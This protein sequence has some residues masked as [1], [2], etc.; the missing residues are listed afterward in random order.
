VRSTLSEKE[1]SQGETFQVLVFGELIKL[2][3]TQISPEP[4]KSIITTN[5][6]IIFDFPQSK[7]ITTS[8]T[9]FNQN[10]S[11]KIFQQPLFLLTKI[12]EMHL[13]KE[14]NNVTFIRGALLIG[15]PGCGKTTL[16]N[17]IASNKKL[18]LYTINAAT[19]T[20]VHS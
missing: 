5:T 17:Y 20:S 6:Q 11:L 16:I 2:A 19:F 1:W 13:H 9:T 18:P 12:I 14:S 15:P 10:I 3:I 7:A 4:T 8:L